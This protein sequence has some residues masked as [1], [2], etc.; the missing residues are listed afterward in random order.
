MMMTTL[1]KYIRVGWEWRLELPE[2][3]KALLEKLQLEH[4]FAALRFNTSLAAYPGS[5]EYF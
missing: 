1:M 5:S 4:T 2:G 3:L